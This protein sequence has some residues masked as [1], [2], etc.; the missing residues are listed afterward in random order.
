MGQ[1][2]Q[3]RLAGR[4]RWR[5]AVHEGS[6]AVAMN[7]YGKLEMVTIDPELSTKMLRE[8]HGSNLN[9]HTNTHR[10]VTTYKSFEGRP[11]VEYVVTCVAGPEGEILLMPGVTHRNTKTWADDE[12]NVRE[13]ADRMSM[14]FEALMYGGRM[15]WNRLAKLHNWKESIARVAEALL[16]RQTLTAEE[17][18][19][20]VSGAAEE[21]K[22]KAAQP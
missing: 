11:L 3:K 2:K 21:L 5:V 18:A 10:G 7:H 14:D 9:L 13:V 17:V 19:Q 20:I 22:S 1:A 8:K 16:E 6:H 15:E 12:Y 4:E